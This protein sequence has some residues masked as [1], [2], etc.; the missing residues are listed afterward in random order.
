VNGVSFKSRKSLGVL[1]G[2]AAVFVLPLLAW[3]VV[4][5][6]PVTTHTVQSTV[7]GNNGWSRGSVD[8]TLTSV[9]QDRAVT[10]IDYVVN[11]SVFTSAGAGPAH[12]TIDTSVQGTNTLTYSAFGGSREQTRSADILI[13]STMPTFTADAVAAY[14]DVASITLTASDTISGIARINYQLDS[15]TAT[16]VAKD[17]A[18]WAAK[19]TTYVVPGV[20][21]IGTHT[22]TYYAADSAGNA[23]GVQTKTFVVND[24]LP[25]VTTATTVTAPSGIA[26][27]PVT[28]SL[29]ATDSGSG[30]A[31]TRYSINGAAATTYTTPFIV[32]AEGTTTVTYRS[33]DTSGVAETTKTAEIKILNLPEVGTDAV[34]TYPNIAVIKI[35]ATDTAGGVASISSRID[36]GTTQTTT[37]TPAATASTVVTVTGAGA[38]TVSY[39]ASDTAGNT[40]SGTA[41]F[42]IFLGDGTAPVTT[43]STISAGWNTTDVSFSLS[44]TDP[45]NYGPVSGVKNTFFRLGEGAIT[46]YT[47]PVTVSTEGT[48]V[49][50]YRSVDTSNNSEATKTATV[51]IDKTAPTAP[52]GLTYSSIAPTAVSLAWGAATDS[53][54]GVVRYEVLDGLSIVATRSALTSPPVLSAT[55]GSLTPGTPHAFSVRAVDAAGNATASTPLVVTMPS[56][57]GSAVLAPSAGA[58]ATI[59]VPSAEGTK[60][61]SVVFPAITATGTLTVLEAHE[62]PS[63][64]PGA[65]TFLGAYYDVSFTGSFTGTLTITFP[66]D[67]RIPDGRAAGIKVGHWKNGA[68]VQL[69]TTV[70]T[71]NHTVT[72]QTSSLSPFALVEP[73]ATNVLAVIQPERAAYYPGYGQSVVVNATLLDATASPLSGQTLYLQRKDGAVWSTVAT[74]SPG[75]TAGSYSATAMPTANKAT[76]FQIVLAANTLRYTALSPAVVVVPE[77][78]M[79]TPKVSKTSVA[80]RGLFSVS[81]TVDPHAKVKVT[82]KAYRKS[83]STWKYSKT[84]TKTVT[85]SSSGSY[86]VSLRIKSAGYYKFRSTTGSDKATSPYASSTSA[87][88]KQVR[89]R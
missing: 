26:S 59:G 43:I 84:Y 14:S 85:A 75:A 86:R 17:A 60:T 41:T 7:P 16:D 87:Y 77:M 62:A 57:A 69:P 32:A 80:R 2:V 6:P 10:Q 54:S 49:V 50:S 51:L 79:S 76:S 53:V 35:T 12:F 13:D 8:V 40:R 19:E 61:V 63:A 47:V 29:V 83:G 72:V 31:G 73:S 70:D 56:G 5:V 71:V 38:H 58:T 21:T 39:S 24:T 67:A 45:A 89:V 11:G 37:F 34:S 18:V 15:A 46:T 78:K 74:F 82:V 42:T 66:Y 1:L 22:I 44:A 28:V 64:A 52:A 88:S 68:W 20:R 65:F 55:V 81:G 3:A 23:P 48:T 9:P 30:V 36:A 4:I 33:I 27:G 25:P